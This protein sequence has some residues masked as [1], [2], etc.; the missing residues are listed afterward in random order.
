[1]LLQSRVILFL[2]LLLTSTLAGKI[3]KGIDIHARAK[4]KVS[5]DCDTGCI[6]NMGPEADDLCGT[7][8]ECDEFL[9]KT[10][11]ADM[12]MYVTIGVVV[13]LIVGC[14]CAF[15]DQSDQ[16]RKVEDKKE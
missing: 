1:M 3:K 15:K 8:E 2:P 10:W 5:K 9:R 13:L 12:L 14:C 6:V 11:E 7:T 16:A 4:Y